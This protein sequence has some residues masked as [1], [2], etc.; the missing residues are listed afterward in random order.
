LERESEQ[1]G[2]RIANLFDDIAFLQTQTTEL[3]RQLQAA[4][5]KIDHFSAYHK[6]FRQTGAECVQQ[7]Q[8][9]RDQIKELEARLSSLRKSHG[10]TILSRLVELHGLWN[11][12]GHITPAASSKASL[13][14][15]SASSRPV[16]AENPSEPDTGSQNSTVIDSDDL[17]IL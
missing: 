9:D 3:N 4:T 15:S 17:I 14:E 12:P 13:V 2:R 16:Q 6:I 8:H 7:I 11:E 10:G 5:A 1:K